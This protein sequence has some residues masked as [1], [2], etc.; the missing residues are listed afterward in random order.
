MKLLPFDSFK[1]ETSM[2]QENAVRILCS[3]MGYEGKDYFRGKIQQDGFKIYR[4]INYR[5]S[6]L[7]IIRG[8]FRQE[9]EG[10]IISIQMRLHLFTVGFTA[11]WFS[12]VLFSLILCIGSLYSGKINKPIFLFLLIIMLLFGWA[13][14][15]GCFW[16]EAKKAKKILLEMFP[17]KEISES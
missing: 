1:I 17:N 10:V 3:R 16:Y 5:N 7:P 13:L 11:V 4:I 12:G 2:S 15:N 8:R 14:V 9:V 6:F